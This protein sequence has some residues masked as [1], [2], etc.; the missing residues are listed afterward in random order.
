M[1]ADDL[2]QTSYPTAFGPSH[3][4]ASDQAFGPTSPPSESI[5]RSGLQAAAFAGEAYG[6]KPLAQ[7]LADGD[8]VAVALAALGTRAP[9]AKAATALKLPFSDALSPLQYHQN[10]REAYKSLLRAMVHLRNSKA[11]PLAEY[12]S[13]FAGLSIIFR[14]SRTHQAG[15]GQLSLADALQV[16]RLMGKIGHD[17]WTVLEPLVKAFEKHVGSVAG[18]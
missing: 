10:V 6:L 2:G 11:L 8:F 18:K 9:A 1:S 4:C 17:A 5:S 14:A 12:Q 3:G 15:W 16:K 7:S 13:L